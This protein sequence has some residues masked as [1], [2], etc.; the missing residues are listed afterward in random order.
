MLTVETRGLVVESLDIREAETECC[1]D[2][3]TTLEWD[4]H[5]DANCASDFKPRSAE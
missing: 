2:F 3:N 5:S 4:L 1:F